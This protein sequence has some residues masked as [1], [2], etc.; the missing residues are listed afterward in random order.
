M[1]EHNI[2][3]INSH[4][5]PRRKYFLEQPEGEKFVLVG[6]QLT[7]FILSAAR[8]SPHLRLNRFFK[9]VQIMFHLLFI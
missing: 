5:V 8:A 2:S 3:F 4:Y 6:D 9:F 7:I 1:L